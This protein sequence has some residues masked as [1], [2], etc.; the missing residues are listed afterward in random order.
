MRLARNGTTH[1]EINSQLSDDHPLYKGTGQGDPKSSFGYNV[2]AAP[3]NYYLGK[4]DEV[5]RFKHQG[6]NVPPVLIA[7]DTLLLLQGDQ[8]D[9]ILNVLHKI[10]D[11]FHV[12]GLR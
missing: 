1:F 8:I 2:S 11:Y 6:E 3:L 5:P 4:D 7:D 9:A 10:A 12:S